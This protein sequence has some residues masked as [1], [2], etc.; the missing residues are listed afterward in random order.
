MEQ[1]PI[2]NLL[3]EIIEIGRTI[4][5]HQHKFVLNSELD[6]LSY[7]CGMKVVI[8]GVS[9]FLSSKGYSENDIRRAIKILFQFAEKKF[10]ELCA[11]AANERGEI[12]DEEDD[13]EYFVYI[14][15]NDEY[16]E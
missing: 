9:G 10:H 2:V 7:I 8:E 16:P 13:R 4:L 15:N 12:S 3:D 1:K 5:T 11:L 14:Y 6:D